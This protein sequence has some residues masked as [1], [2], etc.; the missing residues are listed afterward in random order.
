MFF[1]INPPLL[2]GSQSEKADALRAVSS[3]DAI[4]TARIVVSGQLL[5]KIIDALVENL[6]TQTAREK[7][8]IEIIDVSSETPQKPTK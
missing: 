6:Q 3:L 7:G 5:P 8:E 1:Q 2:S 4:Q